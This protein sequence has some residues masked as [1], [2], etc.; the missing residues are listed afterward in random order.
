VLSCVV[1][2]SAISFF[3]SV[4]QLSTLA[5][6]GAIE[7]S[8][9]GGDPSLLVRHRKDMQDAGM[10][11]FITLCRKLSHPEIDEQLELLDAKL[12]ST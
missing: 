9:L 5:L 3:F 12:D 6:I 8:L 1:A 2:H 4:P 10:E 7:E 11:E